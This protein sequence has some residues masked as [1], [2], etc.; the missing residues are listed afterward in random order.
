MKQLKKTTKYKFKGKDPSLLDF[1]NKPPDL[2]YVYLEATEVTSLCPITG[3]PD[4][5]TIKI[6]YRP[7]LHCVESKS[8]KLYLG[9]FRQEGC[10]TETLSTIIAHD[11]SLLLNTKVEVT[12]ESASRGG[13]SIK[14]TSLGGNYE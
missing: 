8:L 13:I 6:N 2:E 11:L 5:H 7:T 1:F 9:S 10:F 12:V 3:Q 4:Y 14:G